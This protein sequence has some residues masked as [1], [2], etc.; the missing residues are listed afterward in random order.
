MSEFDPSDIILMWSEY[1][2]VV[3][4]W[5]DAVRVLTMFDN[6]LYNILEYCS[7][8]PPAQNK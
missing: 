3:K 7:L 1:M 6:K 5:H 4:M 8:A 2:W